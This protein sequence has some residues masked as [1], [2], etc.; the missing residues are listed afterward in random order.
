[1]RVEVSGGAHLTDLCQR[2]KV[3]VARLMQ[4]LVRVKAENEGQEKRLDRLR[5]QNEEIVRETIAAKAKFNQSM[6]LLRKYQ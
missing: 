5:G 2:D 6:Q 1:G 3:K 4:E